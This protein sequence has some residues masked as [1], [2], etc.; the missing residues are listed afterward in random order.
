MIMRKKIPI[1][2]II[3]G[4]LFI[5]IGIINFI[6]TLQFNRE[7]LIQEFKSNNISSPILLSLFTLNNYM[8]M[9]FSTGFVIGGIAI[10]FL[11]GWARKLLIIIFIT[12]IVYFFITFFTTSFITTGYIF[13]FISIGTLIALGLGILLYSLPF[14]YLN[15][16]RFKSFFP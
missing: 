7:T 1:D 6:Q 13:S 4:G 16:P 11:Q 9:I 14:L 15:T 2:V 12:N 5:I 3:I 10:L 8:L